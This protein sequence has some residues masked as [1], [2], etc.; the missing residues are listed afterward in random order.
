MSNFKRKK[1]IIKIKLTFFDNSWKKYIISNK[2][3]KKN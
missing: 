1:D 2:K 3:K